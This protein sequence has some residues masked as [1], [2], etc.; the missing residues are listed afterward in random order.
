MWERYLRAS[1][2]TSV[3]QPIVHLTNGQVIAYEILSRITD[4]D[5]ELIP[6]ELLFTAAE[7]LGELYQLDLHLLK[8]SLQQILERSVP[9]M[10]YFVNVMPESL[11]SKELVFALKE[12]VR[13]SRGNMPI[14]LEI[15]E[16]TADP[17]SS[18][19]SE[20]LAPYRQLGVEVAIDDVGSGYA[21]LNRT[22]E[23][24]PDWMKLD[25]GLVRDVDIN[26]VKAAMIAS[27]VTFTK[28]MTSI[29]IIAEG[30]ETQGELQT[31]LDLGIEV[32]QGFL[33]AKPAKDIPAERFLKVHE[34]MEPPYAEFDQLTYGLL[35]AQYLEKVCYGYQNEQ[36]MA[37]DACHYIKGTLLVDHVEVLKVSRAGAAMPLAV[38]S[39]SVTEDRPDIPFDVMKKMIAGDISITQDTSD[40]DRPY[41]HL[42]NLRSSLKVPIFV[43]GKVFGLLFCGYEKPYQIRSEMI[44]VLRG[45]AAVLA[46]AM[47]HGE[48][49]DNPAVV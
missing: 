1:R 32:G 5:G 8:S 3:F 38:I 7:Q 37:I 10:R 15:S 33:M 2:I 44:S 28:R 6:I 31:L 14:V 13:M 35:L 20:L 34:K 26:A 18:K 16:F 40:E 48:M 25:I 27:V 21:G 36:A 11:K 12:F 46:V 47:A 49:S 29:R 43:R 22:V 17:S 41:S 30:I 39:E 9:H 45:I 24:S 4:K 42:L 23:I 19:W